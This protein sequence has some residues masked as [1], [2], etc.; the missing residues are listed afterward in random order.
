M[1]LAL[2]PLSS[3]GCVYDMDN[4]K[5][6]EE[7]RIKDVCASN[8]EYLKQKLFKFIQI[9]LFGFPFMRNIN[10]VI[11]DTRGQRKYKT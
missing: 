10:P 5:C 3:G 4:G 9:G 11:M 6:K 7:P 8:P 1:K 2:R